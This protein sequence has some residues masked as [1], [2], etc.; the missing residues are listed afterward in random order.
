MRDDKSSL[1]QSIPQCHGMISKTAPEEDVW[2]GWSG[3][4]HT[5]PAPALM[6][7]KRRGVWR[8][9]GDS[10][11]W[12]APRLSWQRIP[13]KGLA[14]LAWRICRRVWQ[15]LVA[16]RALGEQMPCMFLHCH[17]VTGKGNVCALKLDKYNYYNYYKMGLTS[18]FQQHATEN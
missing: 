3:S 9:P 8:G 18:N 13:L 17:L 2:W 12:A 5:C 6:P 4:L 1:I 10:G 15:Q 7:R 11:A 14:A 16:M